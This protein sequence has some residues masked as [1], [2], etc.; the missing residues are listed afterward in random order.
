MLD[1]RKSGMCQWI[2][3]TVS[4][5]L[6]LLPPLHPSI[7]VFVYAFIDATANGESPIICLG[8]AVKVTEWFSGLSSQLNWSCVHYSDRPASGCWSGHVDQGR[9]SFTPHLPA[10]P[11]NSLENQVSPF[12]MGYWSGRG[13]W[14][15]EDH[16]LKKKKKKSKS[17]PVFWPLPWKSRTIFQIKSC[18]ILFLCV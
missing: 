7:Y 17:T 1:E 18:T 13:L 2:L 10:G 15:H 4:A 11:H 3:I 14:R 16:T 8:L 9:R 5:C 12:W 6:C